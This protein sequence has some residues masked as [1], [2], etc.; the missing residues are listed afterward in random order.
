M[1]SILVTAGAA[2]CRRPSVDW[3]WKL[4]LQAT[5]VLAMLADFVFRGLV[6]AFLPDKT[7]FI[8]LYTSA[9][10][11]RHGQNFYDSALVTTTATRLTGCGERIAPVYPP[12]TLAAISVFT[13]LSWGWAHFLWLLLSLVGVGVTIWLLLQLGKFDIRSAQ[14][15][16]LITL[17][18]AFSPLHQ[19]LHLANIAPIV[20]PLC[21]AAIL[22]AERRQDAWAGS[23]LALATILKPQLGIWFLGYYLI[24]QRKKLIASAALTALPF[25]LVLYHYPI[26]E[27]IL[28]ASYRQ[29]F[30][31]WFGVGRPFGFTDGAF[32][33]NVNYVQIVLFQL[34]HN[35]IAVRVLAHGI[36]AAGVGVWGLAVVRTKFRVPVPLA[37][38]SLLGL[39]F[40]S[41][42]HS[43]S[44]AT[45]LALVLC[46][47][48]Q[49][50]L[51]GDQWQWPKRVAC[52]IFCL[53]LLPGHSLLIRVVP[54]LPPDIASAWW[55]K[56]FVARY[57]VWLLLMF[58]GVL[59][60]VL[61]RM[62]FPRA[63]GR[64]HLQ[65]PVG[66]LEN[67]VG[68]DQPQLQEVVPVFAQSD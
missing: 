42:Y 33:F 31:H 13:F 24:Q 56:L 17:V 10:L 37:L 60:Y 30:E 4:F 66:V 5:I 1:P 67:S 43:V 27:G 6:I 49:K 12:T 21:L 64:E 18:M 47:A 28:L 8:E 19:A 3:N 14:A 22:L 68:A 44:D 54:H 52:F 38:S 50:E 9:W 26:S 23:V 40:L 51:R 16:L 62:A 11:W 61:A 36:F 57:F 65:S 58:N 53:M 15:R 46:W 48:L 32:P 55:W 39:S 35:V 20:V 25:G 29:N 2:A 41:M 7:D 59:L 63:T 34:W 45:I